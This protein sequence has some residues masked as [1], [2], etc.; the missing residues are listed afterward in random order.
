MLL[1]LDYST[2]IGLKFYKMKA[3][4]E[5]KIPTP[6]DLVTHASSTSYIRRAVGNEMEQI[7]EKQPGR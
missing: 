2:H 7:Y 1:E 5:E 3:D 6:V 4:S